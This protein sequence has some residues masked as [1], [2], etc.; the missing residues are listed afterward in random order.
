M[1]RRSDLVAVR[2]GDLETGRR[3]KLPRMGSQ[4]VT[5]IEVRDDEYG[6]CLVDTDSGVYPCNHNTLIDAED[7]TAEVGL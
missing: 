1:P 3:I 6:T 4:F 5:V 2:A 7:D